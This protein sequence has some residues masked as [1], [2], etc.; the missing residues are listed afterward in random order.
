M[1]DLVPFIS[2]IKEVFARCDKEFAF[3]LPQ[4]ALVGGKGTG[5]S[6]LLE[7]LV[8]KN[9]LPRGATRAPLVLNLQNS[10][11]L[12]H[13][14]FLHRP[15]EKIHDFARIREEIANQTV[16]LAGEGRNISRTPLTLT[17]FSP[18]VADLNLIDLPG[19]VGARLAG[20]PHDFVEQVKSTILKYISKAGTIIL[21]VSDGTE[22]L[23]MSQSLELAKMVDPKGE[24]RIGVIIKLDLSQ[25]IA[26]AELDN[27]VVPLKLGHVGVDINNGVTIEEAREK[28]ELFFEERSEFD[29]LAGKRGT[30]YLSS[31]MDELVK[32]QIFSRLAGVKAEMVRGLKEATC[33]IE[34][35]TPLYSASHQRKK[36][37]KLMDNIR[38]SIIVDLTGNS[39]T[40]FPTTTGCS[41]G[42]K[43]AQTVA[44]HK[45]KLSSEICHI[46]EETIGY[47][48]VNSAGVH[49]LHYNLNSALEKVVHD[50]LEKL[51][52][53]TTAVIDEAKLLMVNCC[54]LASAKIADYPVL[55]AMIQSK[56]EQS[57]ETQAKKCKNLMAA[58]IK[59]H[60][61]FLDPD[62]VSDASPAHKAIHNKGSKVFSPVSKLLGGPSVSLDQQKSNTNDS[63]PIEK[64]LQE[65]IQS[66]KNFA[67]RHVTASRSVIL[68]MLPATINLQMVV[69]ILQEILPNLIAESHDEIE[70]FILENMPDADDLS[71]Y[72]MLQQTCMQ[73]IEHISNLQAAHRSKMPSDGFNVYLIPAATLFEWPCANDA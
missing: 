21:A 72:Q 16:F 66:V 33:R 70:E 71:R 37:Y 73:S 61:V 20:Q 60:Q 5:K 45:E 24:R 1:E 23:A 26:M 3:D 39:S 25:H 62:V 51:V 59:C 13:G 2:N 27:R 56:L 9:F 44:H 11:C 28:E 68:A 67:V 22:G 6:S 55:M 17:I 54:N 53:P 69:K 47:A 42:S 31:V 15:G 46:S 41:S 32:S 14:I 63:N 18:E 65:K 50:E 35:L 36:I 30:R 29:H 48:I 58:M 40:L 34:E 8:G 7:T 19:I 38:N 52:E 10:N 64:N 57:V 49:S 12:E 43:I 4:I